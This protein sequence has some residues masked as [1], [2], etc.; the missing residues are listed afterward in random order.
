[1]WPMCILDQAAMLFIGCLYGLWDNET[2]TKRGAKKMVKDCL[3]MYMVYTYT[4]IFQILGQCLVC[5]QV[6]EVVCTVVSLPNLLMLCFALLSVQ[7]N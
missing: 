1:M 6:F 5:L 2:L 3:H 4:H 7:Q